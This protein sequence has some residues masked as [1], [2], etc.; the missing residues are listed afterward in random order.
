M[1]VLGFALL[2]LFSISAEAQKFGAGI[3]VKGGFPFTDLIDTT[4][5]APP[6]FSLNQN[7]NY[8]VG[9]AA[10]IRIPFGF[11]FEVDGLYRGTQYHIA[12]GGTL[13]TSFN[14]ASW[15]VPYLGKFRFPI[16]LLKPFVVAG[17]AWRTFT[18]LPSNVSVSHNAFVAGGGLELRISRLRLSGE[19]RY[20]R[21]G[22][23]SS[24]LAVKL[25]QNQ[26]EILFGIMF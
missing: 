26:G 8:L 9:P 24:N 17:G 22:S 3:G 23:P 6:G 20:L 11:A 18:D 5:L 14:S 13:P 16:P 1:R 12:N 15:E 4:S 10:E 25:A 19:A 2:A 7:N 21:W